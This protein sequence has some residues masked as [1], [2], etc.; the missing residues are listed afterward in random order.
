MELREQP[1]EPLS[2]GLG[3]LSEERQGGVGVDGRLG[4]DLR[5][6]PAAVSVIMYARRSS[7]LRSRLT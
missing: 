5:P 1:V 4:P 2:L 3:K 7:G 6:S